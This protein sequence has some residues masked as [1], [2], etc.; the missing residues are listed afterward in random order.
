MLG[1]RSSDGSTALEKRHS[2]N[3]N[4]VKCS[5]IDA[6]TNQPA[7]PNTTGEQCSLST[8]DGLTYGNTYRT[9]IEKLVNGRALIVR[10]LELMY[11]NDKLT[12]KAKTIVCQFKHANYS[13][14]IKTMIITPSNDETCSFTIQ[15]GLISGQTYQCIVTSSYEGNTLRYKCNT[16]S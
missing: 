2:D 14:I 8:A 5:Y 15:D 16:P 9:T 7:K 11:G 1:I 3:N 6:N 10:E 13:E 12:L 4:Q